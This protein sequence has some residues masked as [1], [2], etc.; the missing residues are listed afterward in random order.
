M[1][2]VLSILI[3]ILLLVG[4]V[5]PSL[6]ENETDIFYGLK[7]GLRVKI[8][9]KNDNS[10]IGE[11]KNIA[12][13]KIELNISFDSPLLIGTVSFY[14][15]EIKAIENL[16][17]YDIAKKKEIIQ[18]KG[19]DLATYIN[20]VEP[21]EYDL[22]SLPKEKTQPEV[23]E[24]EEEQL[25]KLL[26]QFP[27]DKDWDETRRKE[28]QNK[29]S[30]LR[31][32][33]ENEFLTQYDL[34][35]QAQEIK[36]RQDRKALLEKFLPEDG[37]NEEKHRK[38]VSKPIVLHIRLTADEQEF[39]NRFSDWQQALEERAEEERKQKEEE[40]QKTP[41]ATESGEPR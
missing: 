18:K 20:R 23:T 24:S 41:P 33:E 13:D 4:F 19:R 38:L 7:R 1:Y 5:L 3:N 15:K 34:W 22:L 35:G 37:W 40:S 10:F 6:A 17:S 14:K 36:A 21:K 28:I 29:N 2:K 8:I 31:T 16:H 32:E 27:P 12:K 26:E 11:I 30:A 39:V 25:L 9:V